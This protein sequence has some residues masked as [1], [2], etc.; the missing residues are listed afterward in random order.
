MHTKSFQLTTFHK[1]IKEDGFW[2]LKKPKYFKNCFCYRS[3]FLKG[4]FVAKK[5]GMELEEIFGL[6]LNGSLLSSLKGL[7]TSFSKFN[8]FL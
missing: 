3:S 7:L 2:Q 6:F 5:L 8:F 1:L 4:Y